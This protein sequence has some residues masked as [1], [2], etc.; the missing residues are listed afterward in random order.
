MMRAIKSRKYNIHKTK[1]SA[2]IRGSVGQH[3]NFPALLKAIDEQFETLDKA[4]ESTQTM[5]FSSLKLTNVKNIR[6]HIMKVRGI[7]A[8]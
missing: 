3:E 6:E 4:L 7:A 1:I 8:Q 2:G 5:N